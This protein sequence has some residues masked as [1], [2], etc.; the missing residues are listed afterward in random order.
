[1]GDSIVG[2]MNVDGVKGE[3]GG[4]EL[5]GARLKVGS[6]ELKRGA[7]GEDAA[8]ELAAGEIG[9]DLRPG[10]D[11]TVDRHAIEAKVAPSEGEGGVG[12]KAE[13]TE[14]GSTGN[15]CVAVVHEHDGCGKNP[16]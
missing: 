16:P 4:F 13:I 15:P 3:L 2:D 5:E 1:G 11:R 8:E 7:V 9:C 12:G 6:A 10:Y 14:K